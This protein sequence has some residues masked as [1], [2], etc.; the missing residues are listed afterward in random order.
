M[1][2]DR[3]TVEIVNAAGLGPGERAA[4]RDL[5]AADPSLASPYFDLRFI[6]IAAQIAPGAQLAIVREG[7]AVRGFLPF[8]KRDAK[9]LA[10]E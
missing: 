3:M 6:E 10:G 8:Q 7:D 5:R 2:A 4:W 9:A 1:Q